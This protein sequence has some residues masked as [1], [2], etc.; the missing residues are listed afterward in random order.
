MS[1]FRDI[2]ENTALARGVATH[3]P[4]CALGWCA[5]SPHLATTDAQRATVR[6]GK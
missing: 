1:K 2:R 6:L 4:A 5:R 3:S